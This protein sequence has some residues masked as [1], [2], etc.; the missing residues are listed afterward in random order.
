MPHNFHLL[1]HGAE[2][3]VPINIVTPPTREGNR[4]PTSPEHRKRQ[5]EQHRKT[6]AIPSTRNK[7]RVVLEDAW[8]VVSEVELDEESSN[9]LT[10][11]DA[12]LGRVVWDIACVLDELWEVDLLET[13]ALY[14][15]DELRSEVLVWR[16]DEFDTSKC[17]NNV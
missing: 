13:E 14:L 2:I 3:V 5:D 7:V 17:S 9:D 10:E 15:G 6:S 12:S 16:Q 8:S 11:N 4:R 1:G